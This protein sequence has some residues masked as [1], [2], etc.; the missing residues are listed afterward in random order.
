MADLESH[1]LR[2]N[3]VSDSWRDHVTG[4]GGGRVKFLS[5]VWS[6]I[7]VIFQFRNNKSDIVDFLGGELGWHYTYLVYQRTYY[8]F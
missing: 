5:D 3:K 2:L 1:F 4:N 8:A 6:L 7:C